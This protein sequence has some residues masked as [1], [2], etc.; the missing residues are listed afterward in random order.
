MWE[1]LD[2]KLNYASER[3]KKRKALA[4]LTRIE[5]HL[6]GVMSE[7]NAM[8]RAHSAD[9]EHTYLKQDTRAALQAL[10]RYRASRGLLAPD[11][12]KEEIRRCL[13]QAV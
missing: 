10:Q 6:F 7:L 5:A 2:N 4:H 9:H 3:V 12:I 8:G 13:R 1:W 11:K